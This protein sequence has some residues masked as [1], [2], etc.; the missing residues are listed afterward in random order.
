M[1]VAKQVKAAARVAAAAVFAAA[2]GR[3]QAET[4]AKTAAADAVPPHVLTMVA[5]DFAF[6]APDQVPAGMVTIQLQNRGQALHHVALM[7]LDGGK[8]LED[9]YA[10]L[11]AGGPPPAWMHDMGGPNAPDPGSD[12][13]ATL[14]LQPGNYALLCFV[15]IPDHVP[16]VMKGMAKALT[17]TPAVVPTAAAPSGD[18]TMRLDDYSFTTSTPITAGRHTIR[19]ENGAAQSHEVELIKLAPGKTAD[20]LMAWMQS[21]QGPPP[22]SAIGGISGMERGQV[23][24]FTHDFTPG[25]YVLI[26]FL[27]DARDGKPHFM[28]GMMRTITVS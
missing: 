4:P 23:Q 19:V 7:K 15:D 25:T 20:D 3:A 10:A 17:V 18:I 11:R 2:C 9:V 13:N 26:C 14:F 22:A 24:S 27:P 5:R 12:A 8:T 28:H 16:H 1:Q 21:M 6:Q